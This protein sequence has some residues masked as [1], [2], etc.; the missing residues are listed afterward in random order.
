MKTPEHEY[1]IPGGV[2]QEAKNSQ[3]RAGRAAGGGLGRGHPD[4]EP[5]GSFAAGAPCGFT[6]SWPSWINIE[7]F[8]AYH[9]LPLATK[10]NGLGGLDAVLIFN[11]K[12]V[13]R[14]IAQLAEWQKTL[15]PF[16]GVKIVTYHKDFIY[17]ATRF[18]LDVVENLEPKPG[19]APSPAH[20]ARVIETMKSTGAKV[21]L[22][23]PFQN[24][25]TA[26]NVARQTG[27]VVLEMPQQPGVRPG[28]DSYFGLMDGV[29]DIYM[30]DFKLWDRERCRRYLLAPDYADVA[31][32]TRVVGVIAAVRGQVKGHRDPLATG[33]QGLA[34][35]GVGLLSR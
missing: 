30:P 14:H 9:N 16:K 24:R 6:T 29:I 19:I 2:D 18:N 32:H 23:Q 20:L 26:D 17:L 35:K 5:G 7:N 21:I 34:I 8:S 4:R 11:N 13:V 3:R 12:A 33:G 10:S 31:R 28:T 25:K 27:G 22:V 15:A 1:E